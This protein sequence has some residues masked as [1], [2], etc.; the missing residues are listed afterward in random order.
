MLH[1]LF[2]TL[3][4]RPDLVVDHASAYAALINQEAKAAGLQVVGRGLAWATAAVC[5]SIF[6]I[7]AG[8]AMMLG[9][10]QN[11]FHWILIVVPGAALVL[12][13]MAIVIAKKPLPVEHFPLL[14]EQLDSDASALRMAA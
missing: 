10:V 8:S 11:Q 7:L 1:P 2:S 9:F 3:I 13:V 14:K 4:Q 5:G 12:T 6:M